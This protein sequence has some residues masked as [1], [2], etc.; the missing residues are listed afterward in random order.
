MWQ[1][2]GF[3]QL[4]SIARLEVE[5]KHDSKGASELRLDFWL[6]S[7]KKGCKFRTFLFGL[8]GTHCRKV[9]RIRFFAYPSAWFLQGSHSTSKNPTHESKHDSSF[10]HHMRTHLTYKRL[11]PLSSSVGKTP[12]IR[13]LGSTAKQHNK[14]VTAVSAVATFSW[15]GRFRCQYQKDQRPVL[16]PLIDAICPR[17]RSHN[18]C[19]F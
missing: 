2:F 5:D 13:L 9:I 12:H 8:H 14:K 6:K 3:F 4:I 18:L 11:H 16:H 17:T 1:R 19:N 7:T 10:E 15:Q